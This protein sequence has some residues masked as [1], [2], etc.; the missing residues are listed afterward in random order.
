MDIRKATR[1]DVP[2][3]VALLADDELGRQRERFEDPLPDCYWAAFAAIDRDANN[4]LIV[5]DDGGEIVGTLQLTF[6]PSLTYQ[7]GWR[8]QIEAVRVASARRGGGVGRRLLEWAMAEACRRGCHLV[9][10]TTDRRRDGA[11][12]FYESLGFEATHDGMKR[13]IDASSR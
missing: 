1:A 7:G 4:L 10:L 6:L 5:G 12:R 8:A 13:S 9:Q 2:A 3:I 11:R